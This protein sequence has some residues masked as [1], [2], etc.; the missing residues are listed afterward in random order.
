M[1]INK[2]RLIELFC[3]LAKIASPSG[4]EKNIADFIIKKLKTL[5]LDARCD[6]Y[7]NIIAKLDGVGEP[8]IF[9]AHLDT[10]AVGEGE[11][12]KPV[13]KEDLITSDGTTILG[14]DNKD[15][16]AAILE[17]L[18]ILQETK[19]THRPLEIVFTKEEEAISRGANNLD[20]SLLTGKKCVIADHA[21]PYGTIVLGAP[22]CFRFE[23]QITGRRSHVKNPENGV[24]AVLIAAKAISRL[25]LGRIDEITTS[26]IAFMTAG[27]QNIIN[28]KGREIAS[29]SKENRNTVPDY[30]LI[31][32]EVRGVYEERVQ[33]ALSQF[34]QTFAEEAE[35]LG[36]KSSFTQKQLSYGYVFDQ[37]DSFVSEIAD[38]FKKQ[39]A[40]PRYHYAVGGSDANVLN[41]RGI[42]TVVISSA[43]KNNHQL[44]EYLVIDELVKIADFFL[45]L[46]TG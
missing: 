30:C 21:E 37:N 33:K 46:A 6:D 36:G 7:G 15:A 42:H 5:G 20:V 29:L 4:Q 41:N 28:E 31:Y 43:G 44:S 32:G 40:M 17:A 8:L 34:E 9:C 10:V 27:L 38:V 45:R 13:V 12:I 3:E 14:A 23:S 39:G 1:L 25:S 19:I 24:N 2:Q 11:E 16:I 18:Q 22:A 35:K 26:N